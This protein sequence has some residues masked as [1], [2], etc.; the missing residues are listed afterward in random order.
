LQST[1][2][3]A[4]YFHHT[5]S[6]E[7]LKEP[8]LIRKFLLFTIVLFLLVPSVFAQGP[9][10]III[11][12][13][14]NVE[15]DGSIE[16]SIVANLPNSCVQVENITYEIE[17][18][19]ITVDLQTTT[20]GP[21]IACAQAIVEFRGGVIIQPDALVP[22]TTY[23]INVGRITTTVDY[24]F[25][26]NTTDDGS[27]DGDEEQTAEATSIPPARIPVVCT[28]PDSEQVL[29]IDEGNNFCFIY[30]LEFELTEDEDAIVALLR[31]GSD[32]E[33]AVTFT[34]EQM[35]SR[36]DVAQELRADLEAAL[37]NEDGSR[38]VE[39][40]MFAGETAVEIDMLRGDV[41]SRRVYILGSETFTILTITPIPGM[42]DDAAALWESISETFAFFEPDE[43]AE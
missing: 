24:D 2:T 38:A 41:A 43:E 12:A 40:G 25:T 19:T 31:E 17:N 29:F 1:S 36:T 42:N 35:T 4:Q 10:I 8:H 20:P 11:T 30:P 15:E 13:E 5:H 18:D 37:F 9:R 6:T 34:L 21:G 26:G 23:T 14:A 33:I 28:V 32:E 3:L 7:N 22:G 16:V 27:V 39:Q